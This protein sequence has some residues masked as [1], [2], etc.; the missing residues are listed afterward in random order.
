MNKEAPDPAGK[1]AYP[2]E[3]DID[4]TLRDSF[5]AS[6]PPGWTLGLEAD[7]AVEM[8]ESPTG[9][10]QSP[11]ELLIGARERDLAGGFKVHRVLPF[12]RRRMVGPFI[13]LDQMGP[14]ILRPNTG[15][16][17]APHPHIGLATVTYLFD[18]E[19][20]HRDS[21][22]NVQMIRPGEVNWMT[23]GR[24]IVHSERTPPELRV[25][26]SSILGLQTW[27][28][29]PRKFEEVDPDFVHHPADEL[30]VIEGEGLSVRLISGSLY[31]ANS[32][33][34]TFSGMF[35]ADAELE[36]GSRLA[37]PTDYD[38]RAAFIIDGSIEISG[39]GGTFSAGQLLVFKTGEKV[40]LRA[41]DD[42]AARIMLLGGDPIDG[43]RHIFWNF[44]SSSIERIEEAKADW[45]A[46][47]FPRVPGETGFIPLP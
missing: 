25:A 39:G 26:G 30:P 20:L 1:P 35:Y 37:L 5:P 11:I 40:T 6:D 4:R 18:G 45:Q 44:V 14:E 16:D 41:A 19:L 43:K 13:F 33:V 32:P 21:L 9:E 12:S 8:R 38:E 7:H 15:L 17:V 24:G 29:L 23:A 2:T 22:G 47:R 28:A 10:G 3:A 31:G 46:G 42:R 34:R 27:V 36:K